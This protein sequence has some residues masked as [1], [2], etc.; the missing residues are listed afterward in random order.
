MKKCA[1][2]LLAAVLF[3]MAGV[4]FA[5]DYVVGEEDILKITVYDHPDLTT[6]SR[7]SGEGVIRM[8]LIGDVRV[9]GLTISQISQKLA[10]LLADGYI[11]DPHVSVFVEEFKSKKTT[12]MG[13]VGKPG[14]YMLSGNTT[15]LELL[16]KAGGLTKDAGDKAIIK[17]KA[18][19][20][21]RESILTLDLRKL[22]E[23][24]DTS[25]DILLMDSD[26]IYIAKAGVFYITGEVKKPDA[27]KYEEGTTVI[28]AATMAGGFSD[29]ASSGR[30]KIIRKVQ[31]KEKIIDKAEMDEPILP[32]DIIVVPESFF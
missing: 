24:G 21:Q 3:C 9:T 23:E 11:V 18:S 16:S 7:V 1:V 22:L 26:S 14:V 2:S 12:I 17:R 28:K 13:Q 25:A 20:G 29:K 19:P 6:T 27:Y 30:I 4:T 15:F 10:S 32:D 5:Q 31:G 8:P